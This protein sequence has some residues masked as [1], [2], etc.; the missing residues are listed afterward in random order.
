MT[1]DTVL[2]TGATGLLGRYLLR[3]LVAR[4]TPVAVLIRGTGKQS[5]A[6]R[7]DA[8]TADWDYDLACRAPA[9]HVLEGDL[10]LPGLGLAPA[11]R[12]WVAWHCRQ[13]VHNGASLV[14]HGADRAADP[15][16]SNVSGT[17][18]VLAACRDAGIGA[19]HYVSTAYVC[20][21]RTDTV[22]EDD[23]PRPVAYR[24]DYEA[25]KAEAERLVRASGLA[26]TVYRPAV[27]VGDSATGFTSTYHG[28]YL[29]LQ[30]MW[31]L[32]RRAARGPDGRW[33]APIRY[34]LTG[35][36]RR[37]L[38]PV[39]WVSAVIADIIARPDAHGRTYHLTPDPAVTTRELDAAMADYFGYTGPTFGGPDALAG[40]D[41]NPTEAGYYKHIARY[42]R[43]WAAEPRFDAAN[44]RAAVPG[45]PCPRVDG[46]VIRRL[47]D[48]AVR[49]GWGRGR[50]KRPAVG[51][52]T[53][54]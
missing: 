11:D 23:A 2:L 46:P 43:Y 36:E 16:L 29:Y 27:I 50:A 30:Y 26:A 19:V 39:D 38:V 49:D 17:A 5:A 6:D 41:L 9:V 22:P 44:T 3:D 53:A 24:N 1:P 40:G 31:R 10:T 14:F 18:N 45:R 25:S 35:N 37:N 54:S 47:I 7:L 28:L 32:S 52:A 33:P 51:T 13:V 15:W 21:R 42:E 20:G 8:L 12:R 34:T 48:F 4:G